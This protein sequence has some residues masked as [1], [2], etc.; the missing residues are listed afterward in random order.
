MRR[1]N[2]INVLIILLVPIL[3]A[4]CGG[5]N[6]DNGAQESLTMPLGDTGITFE[7]PSKY[8]FEAQTSENNDF[9]G[10]GDGGN[11][12]IIANHEDKEGYTL[13]EYAQAAAEANKAGEAKIASDGN[14][15]FEYENGDY[16]Y[17][18][19]VRQDNENY[20]RVAFYCFKEDWSD[21]E[22]KF[23]DWAT[24]IKLNQTKVAE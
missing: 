24:T 23:A 18:T 11:W 10:L 2:F 21:Y 6:I 19:A 20:Y 12:A 14:Y 4:G 3:L 15:Y 13:E 16:H 22:S 9:F 7:L 5:N 8:G 1:V 17:Y